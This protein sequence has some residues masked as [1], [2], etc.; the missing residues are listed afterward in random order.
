M[1][2]KPAVDKRTSVEDLPEFM[3]PEEFRAYVGISRSTIYDLLR[4]NE[5]PHRKFGKRIR[6]PKTVLLEHGSGVR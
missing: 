5:I 3:S 2:T 6:I 1:K 4:R